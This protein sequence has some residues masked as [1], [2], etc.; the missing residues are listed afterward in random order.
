[1]NASSNYIRCEDR[2]I[3]YMEW[4]AQ[5]RDTVADTRAATARPS[6]GR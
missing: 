1:M 6:G 3:H 4:G 5:H 2:E